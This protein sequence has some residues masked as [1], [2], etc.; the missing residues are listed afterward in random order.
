VS[1]KLIYKIV[2]V[3]L[4]YLLLLSQYK[5]WLS[6]EGVVNYLN[7]ENNITNQRNVNI[8]N[9]EINQGLYAE[10]NNLQQGYAAVEERARID[11]GL[12]KNGERYYQ[13]VE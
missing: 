1:N 5:I 9:V 11:L 13:I 8:A 12:I 3:F 2:W 4:I 6:D 7:L 10:V